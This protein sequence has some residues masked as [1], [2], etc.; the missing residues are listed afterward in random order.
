MIK[1]IDMFETGAR[2]SKAHKRAI[3][4][5]AFERNHDDPYYSS[6]RKEVNEA[7]LQLNQGTAQMVTAAALP[8]YAVSM[9]WV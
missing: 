6:I 2:C 9:G 1:P 8:D 7:R 4:T 5:G 3:E